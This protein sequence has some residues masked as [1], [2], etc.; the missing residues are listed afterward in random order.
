MQERKATGRR[1]PF[2]KDEK[3]GRIKNKKKKTSLIT[4]EER[5]V[6]KNETRQGTVQE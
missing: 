4:N 1:K 2:Q 6:T 3:E 5:E